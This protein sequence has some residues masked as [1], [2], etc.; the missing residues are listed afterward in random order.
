[1]N[2]RLKKII[3]A[4]CLSICTLFCGLIFACKPAETG[5]D[6]II[7]VNF[8]VDGTV[9]H[10]DSGYVRRLTFPKE[11]E[12]YGYSFD[13]WYAD[14][15]VW[16]KKF[17][18]TS[19]FSYQYSGTVSVYAKFNLE[20]YNVTYMVDTTFANPLNDGV[21]PA[22]YTT[23]QSFNLVAPEVTDSNAT[24]IGWFDQNGTFVDNLQGLSGDKVLTAHFTTSALQYERV[25]GESVIKMG[26]YP[27][28]QV[29]DASL[30]SSLNSILG[31][32]RPNTSNLYGWTAEDCYDNGV[33]AKVLYYKDVTM[34][35]EKYRA[36]YY[37]KYRSADVKQPSSVDTSPQDNNGFPICS[38]NSVYWFKFEPISWRIAKET[39]GTALLIADKIL[40][41][42]EL[43]TGSW[44][45]FYYPAPVGNPQN[46]D[47]SYWGWFY[48]TLRFWLNEDFFFD[49]FN[50][51][52][53]ENYLFNTVIH[54][55]D[56][57]SQLPMISSQSRR[58]VY[59]KVF[60][61]SREEIGDT[62]TDRSVNTT[63][64]NVFTKET[65]KRGYTDYALMQGLLIED[66]SGFAR[67]WLRS[68]GNANGQTVQY[69][70]KTGEFLEEVG[71]CTTFGVV[72][73]I[74]IKL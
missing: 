57:S 26:T 66:N 61:L 65:R 43:N 16:A 31:T 64:E 42:R 32:V 46:I 67:Y 56:Q 12:L 70:T 2:K 7:T 72:P 23:E 33:R 36:V 10:T 8:M 20:T 45:S 63:T 1:M 51:V 58:K 17:T 54:N 41:A 69:V 73:S 22:T 28:S 53:R 11:P 39:D 3:T 74:W 40:A 30:L 52:Q 18:P 19:L 49:A 60:L 71:T 34:S 62:I 5:D 35:G 50:V 4:I 9:Y 44:S 15:G 14:D 55:D 27:Q 48:A 47:G 68:P 37:T 38:N 59:N 29:K 6:D 24:F 13:G 25:A 21:N